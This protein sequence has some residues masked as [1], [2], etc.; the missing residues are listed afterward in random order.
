MRTHPLYTPTHTPT[1]KGGGDSGE[2]FR[3]TGAHASNASIHMSVVVI[4]IVFCSDTR[5]HTVPPPK[6]THKQVTTIHPEGAGAGAA[7]LPTAAVVPGGGQQKPA[8]NPAEYFMAP[9]ASFLPLLP[10]AS[11]DVAR[12]TGGVHRGS[13]GG[14]FVVGCLGVWGGRASGGVQ[15]DFEV[16]GAFKSYGPPPPPQKKNNKKG[17]PRPP[18]KVTQPRQQA[19]NQ[20]SKHCLDAHKH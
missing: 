16:G 18:Q 14:V 20:S 3:R 10:R 12:Q 2:G 11:R 5:I 13:G 1:H 7:A 19:I 6:N 4:Y 15:V 17:T 9:K 8:P